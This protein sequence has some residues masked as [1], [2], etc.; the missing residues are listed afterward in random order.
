MKRSALLLSAII[1]ITTSGCV[2]D[3]AITT[4]TQTAAAL[5]KPAATSANK[6]PLADGTYRGQISNHIATLV[7]KDGLPISYKWGPDYNAPKVTARDS[8]TIWVHYGNGSIRIKRVTAEGFDFEWQR[9][10]YKT[11][12]TM[13]RD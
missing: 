12:G 6:L 4:S 2:K 1:L 10:A 7:I 9:S 13:I 3:T 5:T 8:N 11:T